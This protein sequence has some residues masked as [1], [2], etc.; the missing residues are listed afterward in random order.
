MTSAHKKTMA[1]RFNPFISVKTKVKPGR[2]SSILNRTELYV[3][4][5]LLD[6]EQKKI[7]ICNFI[8]LIIIY[9]IWEKIF[10]FRKYKFSVFKDKGLISENL[11]QYFQEKIERKEKNKENEH[12]W[13]IWEDYMRI[14]CS[15]TT[16]SCKSAITT[17]M[18]KK[19]E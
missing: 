8:T 13:R 16:F 7:S 11:I 15:F 4:D 17:K 14:V 5:A 12:M 18:F 6:H 19:I 10:C 2:T 9:F 1:T 3:C